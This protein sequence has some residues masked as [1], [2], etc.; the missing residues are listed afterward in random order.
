MMKPKT[1]LLFRHRSMEMG[2]V[3]KVM[4]SL[5]N[6]LDREKFDMTVLLN[7]NQGE[8]RNEIPKHVRKIAVAKGKEDMSPQRLKQKAQLVMRRLALAY[9]RKNRNKEEAKLFNNEKF[10]VEI[11][12]DWRDFEAV[13]SSPYHYSKKIGWFHSEIQVPKLQ[14]VVP[15][16]L[17]SFPKFDHIVYCSQRTKDLMHKHYPNLNY[18]PESVIINAI[19]I[20]EIKKKSEENISDFTKSEVPAFVSVGRLHTRKGFHKLMDAHHRLLKEGFKHSV[21]IIGDGEELPNLLAQQK[22]LDVEETFILAGNKMNPYPYIKNA[23][24]FI[25]PSESEAWPLVIS[26][27]LILQKPIIATRVGDVELMIEDG[28]TGHLIRYDASEIYEAMKKFL[29]DKTFVQNI[30]ENLIYIDNQFDN[31]K[32]FNEVEEIILNLVKTKS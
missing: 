4:L 15:M 27:A 18:P 19:P 31:Q 32:I 3:E 23:D 20:E 28:K 29:T 17:K 11:A 9:F 30:K 5:L 7:L 25:M 8:L 22:K 14:P 26:E 12:M 13:L 6:N 2:G 24:F 21:V 16:I 10:N 1:K